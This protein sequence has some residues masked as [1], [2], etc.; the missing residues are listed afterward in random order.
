MNK[1]KPY[2]CLGYAGK[3]LPLSY[4]YIYWPFFNFKI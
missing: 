3:P 4:T 2:E 1:Y